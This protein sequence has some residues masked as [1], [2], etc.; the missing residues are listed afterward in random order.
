VLA[1]VLALGLLI[2][3]GI[4]LWGALT[5]KQ[6]TKSL[7]GTPAPSGAKTSKAAGKPV[8]TTPANPVDNTV[9]IHC[10]AAACPVFVAGPGPTDVQYRGNLGQNDRRVFNGSRL[11][12]QLD[13]AGIVTVTINGRLQPRPRQGVPKTYEVPAQ[14]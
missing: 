10:L 3:G 5:N 2:V 12:V 7:A 13:D 8:R 11:V 1:V 6:S 4:A 14:Q 9:V